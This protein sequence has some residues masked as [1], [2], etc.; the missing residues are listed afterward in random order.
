MLKNACMNGVGQEPF[1][2][3]PHSYIMHSQSIIL[4]CSH[5]M[6]FYEELLYHVSLVDI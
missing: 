3:E 5:F 4:K 2:K 1:I 6:S